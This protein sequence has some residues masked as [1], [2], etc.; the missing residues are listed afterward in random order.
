[1]RSELQQLSGADLPDWGLVSRAAAV[2][3]APRGTSL[4]QAGVIAPDLHWVQRGF[5]ALEYATPDGR[6]R[7]KGIVQGPEMLGSVESLREAPSSFR[8]RALTD[9]LAVAIPSALIAALTRTHL[10][11]SRALAAKMTALAVSREARERELLLASPEERWSTLQRERPGLVAAVSQAE[12]A[13]LIGITPVALSRLKRRLRDR[14]PA[15][16][17]ADLRADSIRRSAN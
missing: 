16:V 5:V 1:M 17:A 15:S 12:L 3:R 11:W 6:A 4:F 9:T 7:T 2:R 10:A 13:A 14:A 8:A